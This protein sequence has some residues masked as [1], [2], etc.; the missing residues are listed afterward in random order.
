MHQMR[1]AFVTRELFIRSIKLLE[2]MRIVI[3]DGDEIGAPE[4]KAEN[5]KD[6]RVFATA[7]AVRAWIN[8]RRPE[9]Q[10]SGMTYESVKA[11]EDGSLSLIGQRVNNI[12]FNFL[13]NSDERSKLPNDPAQWRTERGL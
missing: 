5:S 2:E 1:G 12:V 7:L 3:Q 4:S 6:D 9:L 11:T 8:W 10:A 13:K